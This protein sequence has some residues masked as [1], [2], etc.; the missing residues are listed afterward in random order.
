MNKDAVQHERGPRNSSLRRQQMMF[1][2]G[3][4]PNSVCVCGNLKFGYVTR[5]KYLIILIK[6]IDSNLVLN[7]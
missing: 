4:S 1:D 5:T 3:S 6:F 2:H 7:S